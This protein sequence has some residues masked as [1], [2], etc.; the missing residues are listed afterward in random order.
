MLH[1][2]E[3]G[4]PNCSARNLDTLGVCII[5]QTGI[6]VTIMNQYLRGGTQQQVSNQGN[7]HLVKMPRNG[8][9]GIN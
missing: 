3:V 8:R 4:I 7:R 6:L 9:G 2:A 5:S 1:N